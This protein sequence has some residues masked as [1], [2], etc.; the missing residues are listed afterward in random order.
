MNLERFWLFAAGL[1]LT[2]FMGF[3][4]F[5]L[6]W[7]TL[8]VGSSVLTISGFLLVLNYR[9]LVRLLIWRIIGFG[10]IIGGLWCIGLALSGSSNPVLKQ[11]ANILME[12]TGALAV[13]IV[14][15]PLGFFIFVF[16]TRRPGSDM[17]EVIKL[18]Y[19]TQLENEIADETMDTVYQELLAIADLD[20]KLC[21][22]VENS[23][24]ES[25]IRTEAARILVNRKYGD[26][27]FYERVLAEEPKGMMADYLRAGLA[28]A[29][30]PDIE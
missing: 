14:I 23:T 2:T 22:I 21:W 13:M 11:L 4:L 20:A 30:D 27:E 10:N 28:Q 19:T 7:I 29:V 1:W 24:L 5:P 26:K 16:F 25:D 17:R 6:S 9:G 15:A 8:F 12:V 3:G 18:L